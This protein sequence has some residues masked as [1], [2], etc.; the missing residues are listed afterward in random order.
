MLI[1][2]Y[3]SIHAT[4]LAFSS[5]SAVVSMADDVLGGPQ[6][7]KPQTQKASLRYGL[8]ASKTFHDSLK[9]YK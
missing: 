8:A 5:Y 7:K 2:H 4:S 6:N 1:S 9:T 3:L